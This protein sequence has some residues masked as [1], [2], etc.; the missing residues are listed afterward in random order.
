MNHIYL[1]IWVVG[2]LVSLRVYGEDLYD[3]VTWREVAK[4][5]LVAI[6]WPIVLAA[7]LLGTLVDLICFLIAVA[8]KPH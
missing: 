8:R 5:T 1:L 3:A 7:T 6:F 2:L 4:I